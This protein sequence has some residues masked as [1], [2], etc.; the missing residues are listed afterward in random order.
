MRKLYEVREEAVESH[1]E[2]Q[3]RSP[4]DGVHV[5]VEIL[6]VLCAVGLVTEPGR[7]AGQYNSLKR[8]VSVPLE[9]PG[10]ARSTAQ[11]FK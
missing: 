2:N 5:L 6:V 10:N 1:L 3:R 8:G 4:W 11:V 9:L 7:E